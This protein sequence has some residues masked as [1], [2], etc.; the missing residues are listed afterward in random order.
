MASAAAPANPATIRPPCIVRP[1]VALDFITV[2]PTVT[3]PS[4]PRA[5]WRSRLTARIVVA[6]TRGSPP[7]L[8][9]LMQGKLA[10]GSAD[11][12]ATGGGGLL[13][14]FPLPPG[15][16]GAGRRPAGGQVLAGVAAGVAWA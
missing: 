7:L 1:L 11:A 13:G 15:G 12:G 4:P 10:D 3:W 9:S 2:S 6:R 5:T 14:H 8:E 16:R